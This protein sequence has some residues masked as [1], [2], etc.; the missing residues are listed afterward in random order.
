MGSE[1]CIRDSLG[2]SKHG[3]RGKYSGE[4]GIVEL[5]WDWKVG[6]NM[7]ILGVRTPADG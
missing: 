2:S 3:P 6:Y 5:L 7:Y 1:M 4:R